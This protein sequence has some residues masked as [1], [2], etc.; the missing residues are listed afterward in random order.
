M[1]HKERADP[2]TELTMEDFN[3]NHYKYMM[4]KKAK[5]EKM[6]QHAAELSQMINVLSE[7]KQ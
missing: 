1:E 7:D 6:K 5:E 2:I 4:K 3:K